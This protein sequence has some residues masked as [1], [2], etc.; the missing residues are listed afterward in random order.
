MKK[1]GILIALGVAA[2][3]LALTLPA[4]HAGAGGTIAASTVLPDQGVTTRDFLQQNCSASVYNDSH[5]NGLDTAIVVVNGLAGTL[6]TLHW[7]GTVKQAVGKWGTVHL[8]F[9]DVN[10]QQRSDAYN[11]TDAA[12]PAGNSV[13]KIP[14]GSQWMLVEPVGTANINWTL[15]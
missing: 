14:A 9:Y 6:R 13:V 4:G 5:V 10:C 2:A 8:S 3:P 7:D 11:G 1:L 15:A 12:W